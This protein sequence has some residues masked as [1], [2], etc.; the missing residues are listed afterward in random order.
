M[1][2]LECNQTI[3]NKQ[4]YVKEENDS[5]IFSYHT[6]CHLKK[7]GDIMQQETE[8]AQTSSRNINVD[9]S[10]M[11]NVL[12]LVLLAIAIICGLVFIITLI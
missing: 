10:K 11:S 12:F 4:L 7:F 2:C 6:N 8:L 3:T 1:N 9:V 5:G